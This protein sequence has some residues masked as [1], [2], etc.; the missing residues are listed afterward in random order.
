MGLADIQLIVVPSLLPRKTRDR[1]PRHLSEV[2]SGSM[3]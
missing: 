3:S 2:P 1:Q